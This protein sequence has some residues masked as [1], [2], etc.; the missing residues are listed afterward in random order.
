MVT[1]AVGEVNGQVA[2]S[3]FCIFALEAHGANF[4]CHLFL[5]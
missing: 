3:F 2:A 1:I 5:F 4:N